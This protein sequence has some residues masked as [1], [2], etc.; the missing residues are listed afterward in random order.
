MPWLHEEHCPPLSDADAEERVA[1]ELRK[2]SGCCSSG[3]VCVPYEEHQPGRPLQRR[4]EHKRIVFMEHGCVYI[5]K[6][7]VSV[8]EEVVAVGVCRP[9][10]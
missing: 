9:A 3:C 7:L 4:N 10:G 8:R 6:F 5:I 2:E 1:R